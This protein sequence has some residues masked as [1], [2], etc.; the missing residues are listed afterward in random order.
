MDNP[1]IVVL[2][3]QEF[4]EVWELMTSE[5]ENTDKEDTPEHYEL[6]KRVVEN[7]KHADKKHICKD[8]KK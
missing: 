3:P 6:V 5:L 1:Y 2:D 7:L 4:M 8:D